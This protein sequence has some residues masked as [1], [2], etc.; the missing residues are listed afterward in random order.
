[1]SANA[2]YMRK[3]KKVVKDANSCCECEPPGLSNSLTDAENVCGLSSISDNST[4]YILNN[5]SYELDNDIVQP[6]SSSDDENYCDIDDIDIDIIPPN[7][8]SDDEHY[9]DMELVDN[10]SFQYNLAQWVVNAKLTR[11][12]CNGLLALLR[13][14]GCEL[15]KDSRTL[16]QTPLAIQVQ[17]KCGGQYIYFGLT[18]CLQNAINHDI[19]S[20]VLNLQINV[21]GIPLFRSS[22]RQFWPILSAVNHNS[23]MIVALYQGNSKPNSVNEFLKD[24]I[25]E[26]KFL[27]CNGVTHNGKN[28]TVILHSV[29]CDA[30]ARSFL[31][32]IVGHNGLHACERCLAVGTSTNRRTTFVSPDCFNARRRTDDS[33]KNLE[34]LGSHQHGASPLNEI[35]DQCI[36]IFPLDYMHLICLGVMRRILQAL[37]K[38][39]RKVKLSNN[40]ILQISENLLDLRK[41]IPSEFARRPRSLLDLD[42]WKATEFRQFLL[43]TGPVVLKG[44][45]DPE[46][47][48]YFLTLSV[49]AS[50]LLTPPNDR[51]NNMLN[52]AKDLLRHFVKNS[53]QLY[54][55]YFV[56]YNIHHLLHIGDDVE[57]FNSPLDNISAFP[58]ENYLQT[59]KRYVR[60]SSNPAVQVAKRIQEYENVHKY[61]DIANATN[62][63]FKLSTAYRDSFAQLKNRQFV[64]VYE[65]QKDSCMCY[66]FSFANLH[67]FFIEP[68]SSDLLDIY[69]VNN[70]YKHSKSKNVKFTE[71][72]RKVLKL[73]CNG[74]FV[75]MPLLHS[76]EC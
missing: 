14:Y 67:P 17:E 11:L 19:C 36:S 50:I 49:A 10:G 61:S 56:V 3:Y 40:N 6:H 71:I 33:Y 72:E 2:E 13:R 28:Y 12:S 21:D 37:K 69:F 43:Y 29:I 76:K 23:P 58:F 62:P 16:L 68:C 64:E 26:Y 47:Y 20:D 1:M 60:G 35:T 30:P 27:K 5:D 31:K 66:I 52:Y 63:V 18:K 4:N 46:R 41:C 44:I 65:V 15:P 39:D 38:G 34:F 24:F 48:K 57:F 25:D 53:Q 74:G 59:L 8:S 70:H 9:C 55:N 51:R 32:N 73:P 45:L 54:G 75:L 22:K 7:S 42:R